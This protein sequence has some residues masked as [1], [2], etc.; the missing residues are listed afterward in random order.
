MKTALA[1]FAAV[2]LICQARAADQVKTLIATTPGL[3]GGEIVLED[4]DSA[5]LQF[6]SYNAAAGGPGSAQ[7]MITAGGTTIGVV[8]AVANSGANSTP[9]YTLNPVKIAGPATVKFQASQAPHF[10]TF[11]ICRAGTASGPVPI[12]QE[13][14]TTWSVILEA[15]SDLVN[16]TAVQPGDYP[17]STPQRY[18][19]T[20]LVKK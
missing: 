3:A 9:T 1:L 2:S 18:F 14:G 11:K 19:R 10:A 16:W 17:S 7:V 4:G 5:E 6:C 12:P 8:T 15:S 20:R 13:A